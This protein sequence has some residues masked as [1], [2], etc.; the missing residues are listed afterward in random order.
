MNLAAIYYKPETKTGRKKHEMS[1]MGTDKA[2]Y[3]RMEVY[4]KTKTANT[5]VTNI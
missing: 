4:T 5:S 1:H 3:T 2:K